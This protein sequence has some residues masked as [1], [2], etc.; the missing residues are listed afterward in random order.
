MPRQDIADLGFVRLCT[1]SEQRIKRHQDASSAEPALQ[2]VIP[3]EGGLQDAESTLL[4]GEALHGSDLAPLDLECEGKTGARG[5]AIDDH[6]AGAANAV[7]A[8]DMGARSPRSR[9]E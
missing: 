5:P 4:V 3:L 2:C 6:R 9:D 7:L 1:A 8:A